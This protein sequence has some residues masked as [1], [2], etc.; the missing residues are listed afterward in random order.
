MPSKDKIKQIKD[1]TVPSSSE[2]NFPVEGVAYGSMSQS[3]VNADD[4][5][6]MLG[7]DN[8][9]ENEPLI[10]LST[11]DIT[12]SKLNKQLKESEAKFRNLIVQAPVLICTFIGPSFTIE[13]INKTA[14][15]IWDKSYEQ[16]INKPLFEVL[17]EMEYGLKRI[18]SEVY[19]T[20]EPY[21]FNEIKVQIKR[22]GKP[23]T[24][25]FNSVYQ[26]LRDL[27]H[28]IYGII[29]IGTE[30]TEAVNARKQNEA[31]E[32]RFSRI[33]HQ[34]PFAFAIL[35]GKDMVISLA[36]DAIKEIWG[37]G[38]VIEGK[39]LF[40]LLPELRASVFPKLLDG[41]YT[42]GL[43][44]IENEILA[45]LEHKGVLQDMYFNLVYQPF[46][47]ADDAILGVVIIAVEVT[48]QVTAKKQIE[49]S[50]TKFRM[51]AETIPIM[52]WTAT[53]E[54][55]KNFF[56]QHFLDYTGL[57]FEELQGDGMLNIIFPD[58]L[59][60]DLLLWENSLK[61]GEDFK[62]EKRLRYHDGTYRWHLSHGIAQKDKDGN[63]IG[64]VGS[65]TDIT[66]QKS[67][68][69]EL[70]IKVKERTE[71]LNVKSKQ[72]EEMNQSLE[73]KNIELEN[74][75]AELAS[76]SYVASHDL[77]EPLRKIQAFSKR[78]LQTEKFS[79]KT[80]DYFNRIISA[81]ERMQN[82]IVS[83]LD[84][85]RTNTEELIFTPCD[86]NI[87]VEES[88]SELHLNILEK[89][90]II[91]YEQLPTI[92]GVYIQL[93]QLFTNIIEN[94]IK[95][96]RAGIKPHII[97]T[98]SNIHGSEIEH[99]AAN[100]QYAY[101]ALKIADNGIGFEEQYETKIFELFQRLHGKTEYSGT[102]IGLA[103]VKKIAINHNGFI[104]AEGKPDIGAAFT[105]YIPI[106]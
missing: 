68:A 38:K 49:L 94:A 87:I 28:K 29:L 56:N 74:S 48:Q 54:G 79:G 23:D 52:V 11:E 13:T 92:N 47:D 45:K 4:V 41:V 24:A 34:S 50:E 106:A 18:L 17:P 62:M 85:S 88:K 86:L 8:E 32:K 58:D 84:F 104:V 102:G 12:D 64:W 25:Y 91:E 100:K 46:L 37:K 40:D 42:T 65:S 89:H 10:P 39:P 9:K 69:E 77:Q 66:E 60:K 80:Q 19:F 103:I 1:K 82:L 83:L 71:E 76:F 90:A 44:H 72:L 31:S 97:I 27:E 33:V 30:V 6:F 15:E 59:K 75:N 53:P 99:P 63:I 2:H 105:I 7:P 22:T 35:R 95:Y 73:L 98:V 78:I 81:G 96:S 51:L 5:D 93:S 57:S 61:T 36:N 43:P 101:Y 20:G 14:L 3:A 67:S 26:P 55:K 70:E 21:L 16:V